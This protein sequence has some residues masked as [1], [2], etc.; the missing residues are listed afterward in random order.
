MN[1]LH[2]RI[3]EQCYY[4]G[5][6]F[7]VLSSRLKNGPNLAERDNAQLYPLY[8]V[9]LILIKVHKLHLSD[10][11][12]ERVSAKL[13]SEISADDWLEYNAGKLKA[14]PLD[15]QMEWCRGFWSMVKDDDGK[16]GTLLALYRRQ[17][18]LNQTEL[19]ERIGVTQKTVSK[20]EIGV[21]R[22]DREHIKKLSEVLECPIED[23]L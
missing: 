15:C 22:P 23:L 16:V 19:A 8:G 21:Y 9:T 10:D 17:K 5:Q 1:D 18:K 6:L 20:W 7:A 12:L 2:D 4:L 11:S 3:K 14:V 13:Y